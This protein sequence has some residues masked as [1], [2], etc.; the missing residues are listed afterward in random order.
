ME[1]RWAS[2]SEPQG[3]GLQRA[4]AEDA[5]AGSAYTTRSRGATGECAAGRATQGMQLVQAEEA[6]ALVLPNLISMKATPQPY[7]CECLCTQVFKP[8][9]QRRS[10]LTFV[11]QPPP[12]GHHCKLPEPSGCKVEKAGAA[13]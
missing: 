1:R 8:R 7:M 3:Y 12:G 13:T 10:A 6:D 5:A 9:K 2:S 11:Q 4:Q